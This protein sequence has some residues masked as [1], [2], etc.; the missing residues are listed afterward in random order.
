MKI[1]P[2]GN[3]YAYTINN[4]GKYKVIISQIGKTKEKVVL[5]GGYK[6]INQEPDKNIPLISWKD[7][8]T[9]GII[10]TKL[11]RNHFLSLC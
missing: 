10:N 11:A 4:K 6:V 9:L 3:Y 7:E 1:S 2:E 5:K 8:N